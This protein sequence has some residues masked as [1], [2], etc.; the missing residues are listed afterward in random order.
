MFIYS[1]HANTIKF[2]AVICLSLATLIAIIAF[3][4]TY[5]TDD[6]TAQVGIDA[7]YN[8]EKIKSNED[9]VNFLKQFGWEVDPQAIKEQQVIIPS[10]FDKV[11]AAYNEI[12]RRQGLDLT[13]FKKKTV[14]RYTYTVKNYPDYDGEVQVNILVYRNNVIGGDV[15]S[16]DVEGFVHGL[17]RK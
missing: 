2:F 10:E 11:F 12:Q 9:R 4:P 7:S 3:V 16:A 17:E 5:V 6:A 15:C 14:M 8:Y 13:P 1:F